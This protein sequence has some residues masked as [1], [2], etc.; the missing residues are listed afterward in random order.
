MF[1]RF[2]IKKFFIL[3][4]I[5]ILL[6]SFLITLILG[7]LFMER[8]YVMQK[9]SELIS[10]YHSIS[11][12]DFRQEDS[13]LKR[14]AEIEYKN[15][16]VVIVDPDTKEILYNTRA[17]DILPEAA[18]YDLILETRT[19]LY[20][21]SDE[22]YYI[23]YQEDETTTTSGASIVMGKMI[24][25]GAKMENGGMLR[26][27]TPYEPIA[28]A[29]SVAIRFYSFAGVIALLILLIFVSR[30]TDSI[31]RPVQEM[32][33][34]SRRISRL[35]FSQKCKIEMNNEIGDLAAGINEM[36]DI[37]QDRT[38]ALVEANEK[39]RQ[40]IEEREKIEQARKNLISNISHDLKTPIALISGYAQGLKSGMAKSPEQVQEY[41]DIISDEADK[42][43][44]LI[45]RLLELSRLES[46]TAQVIM[47]EFDVSETIDNVVNMFKLT[48]EQGGITIKTCYEK[49]IYVSSDYQSVNQTLLNYVQ[50][51]ISHTTGDK[52]VEISIEKGERVRISVF[53]TCDPIPVEELE[54]IWDSFYKLDKS[55]VRSKGGSGLGL[56]IVRENMRLLSMPYG[57]NQT[58][59]GIIFWIEL[60]TD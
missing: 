14:M 48:A 19:G 52:R 27:S 28:A 7:Q 32:M 1:Y 47:E 40:D 49:E 50:N 6:F 39:L 18:V 36:S 30:T 22:P 60:E 3:A 59:N 29:A 9:E 26:L 13:N 41:Y 43:E 20:N 5:C 58:E 34:V 24:V 44:D 17:N 8:I 51:A 37:L 42:M 33:E 35:D 11:G 56:A 55:R 16:S 54:R 53:N 25:L 57:A 2:T 46:G 45:L 4:V 15:I 23:D 31:I 12:M 21:A 38:H 10:I